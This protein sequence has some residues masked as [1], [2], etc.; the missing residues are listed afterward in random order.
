MADE[1]K[2][3]PYSNGL[4]NFVFTLNNYD[5]DSEGKIQA[6]FE[7]HCTYA[8]YGR[9]RGAG[10]TPH[11][12]GYAQLNKRT[13]FNSLRAKLP[14]GTHIEPRRGSLAQAVAYCKKGDQSHEEWKAEREAGLHYGLNASVWEHGEPPKQGKRND[15][16]KVKASIKNGAT[17]GDL[18]EEHF[19]CAVKYHAGLK[20]A[21]EEIQLRD[22][23]LKEKKVMD[24]AIL[25]P[26]QQKVV[27]ALDDLED[28]GDDRRIV[29]VVDTG[30]GKGKSFLCK[31][32]CAKRD[33]QELGNASFSDMAYGLDIRKAVVII[34]L[35]MA[36]P[37]NKFPYSFIEKLRDGRVYSTKYTS[38]MK[39]RSPMSWFVVVFSNTAPQA[40]NL[41]ADRF[42]TIVLDNDDAGEV[43]ILDEKEVAARELEQLQFT[44]EISRPSLPSEPEY[45]F[46][47]DAHVG[48]R[49]LRDPMSGFI[50]YQPPA[51]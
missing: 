32:L 29:W 12:Q 49:P 10:G 8:V 6:F 22:M 1:K 18:C 35:P 33:A 9:E 48:F 5:A 7:E 19:C 41:A 31:W 38:Q 15:L 3:R 13:R 2:G 34:D 37:T 11:L 51:E 17:F 46:R 26:W 28:K 50:S 14:L 47:A 24:N 27:D 20:R 4:R 40:G 43:E 42:V 16:L 30:A 45:L 39:L 44:P 21:Q 36:T 25:R 23:L